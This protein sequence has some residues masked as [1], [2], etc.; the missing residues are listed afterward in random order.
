MLSL[1]KK[2]ARTSENCR[3]TACTVQIAVISPIMKLAESPMAQ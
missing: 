2:A 3:K 1:T